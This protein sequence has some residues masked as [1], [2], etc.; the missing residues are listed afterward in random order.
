MSE[1]YAEADLPETGG[2]S[3]SSQL[4]SSFDY[5]DKG[6]IDMRILG[7]LMDP[8]EHPKSMR[9]LVYLSAYAEIFDDDAVRTLVD[10]YLALTVAVRGRGR[11][12]IIRMESVA[13]GGQA[14]VES[15]IQRPGWLE[16]NITNRRWEDSEREKLGI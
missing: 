7:V 9:S 16:R 14:D 10:N 13:R 1:D 12:D 4:G 5:L 11:R 15:E 6:K 2:A 8:E 3:L